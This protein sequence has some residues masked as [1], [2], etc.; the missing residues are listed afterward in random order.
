MKTIIL[1]AVFVAYVCY[2]KKDNIGKFVSKHIGT[3]PP[4]PPKKHIGTRPPKPP[5]S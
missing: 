4:K 2:I 5:K 1:L 3:R